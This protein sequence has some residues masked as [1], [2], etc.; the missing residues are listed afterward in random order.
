MQLQL[1]VLIF[2]PVERVHQ[3][4]SC[5]AHNDMS[6]LRSGLLCYEYTNMSRCEL[7]HFYLVP[8]MTHLTQ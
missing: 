7:L 3:N 4:L 2:Q 1:Q 5:T 8:A 6:G